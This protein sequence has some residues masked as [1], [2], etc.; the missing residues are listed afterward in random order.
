MAEPGIAQEIS[1]WVYQK[2]VTYFSNRVV[3]SLES[4]MLTYTLCLNKKC[5]ASDGSFRCLYD[6]TVGEGHVSLLFLGLHCYATVRIK[7]NCGKKLKVL[8]N[9]TSTPFVYK[10]T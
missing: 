6:S 9:R 1:L 2:R 4:N 10:K 3:N 7:E 8:G 5:Q